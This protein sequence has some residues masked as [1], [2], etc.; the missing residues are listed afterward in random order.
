M[1]HKNEELR[2]SG[3]ASKRFWFASMEHISR[4]EPAKSLEKIFFTSKDFEEGAVCGIRE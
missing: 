4:D 3:L 2:D 1:R